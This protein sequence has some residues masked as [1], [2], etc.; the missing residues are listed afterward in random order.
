M[1]SKSIGTRNSQCH[2]LNRKKK[3]PNSEWLNH[4]TMENFQIMLILDTA[5]YGS[6]LSYNYT[7]NK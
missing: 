1:H 6:S 3:K 4:H 7:I 2:I 5:H